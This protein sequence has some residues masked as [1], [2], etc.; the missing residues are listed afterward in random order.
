M[1]ARV[2]LHCYYD[3]ARLLLG[4]LSASLKVDGKIAILKHL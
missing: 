3:V 2:L 4:C 1:F